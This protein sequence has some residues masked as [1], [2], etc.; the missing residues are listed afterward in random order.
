MSVG[1]VAPSNAELIHHVVSAAIHLGGWQ[2]AFMQVNGVPVASWPEPEEPPPAGWGNS[3]GALLLPKKGWEAGSKDIV[4]VWQNAGGALEMAIWRRLD[5]TSDPHDGVGGLDADAASQ[6]LTPIALGGGTYGDVVVV[7]DYG[8]F[9]VQID[10]DG[11]V[12]RAFYAGHLLSS[13]RL[14]DDSGG[15]LGEEPIRF[16]LG[17]FS[18]VTGLGTAYFENQTVTAGLSLLPNGSVQPFPSL[19]GIAPR[20]FSEVHVGVVPAA[21]PNDFGT[22]AKVPNL[23]SVC[24]SGADPELTHLRDDSG[25]WYVGF[26]RTL[27]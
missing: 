1:P 12:P 6:V 11:T 25:A 18:M 8:I 27:M 13:Y 7:T 3:S 10:S 26:L 4:A 2:S 14:A 24:A 19:T 15:E 17:A 16:P 9:L 5:G 23:F 20:V 21:P 22:A